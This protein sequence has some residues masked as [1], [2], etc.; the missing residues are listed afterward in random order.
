MNVSDSKGMDSGCMSFRKDIRLDIDLFELWELL[1]SFLFVIFEVELI[2]GD[3]G[4][5]VKTYGLIV[6]C[7]S[8]V[9]VN[10]VFLDDI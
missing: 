3:K 6:M 2:D 5:I 8:C 9:K 7:L 1:F 4:V 10:S